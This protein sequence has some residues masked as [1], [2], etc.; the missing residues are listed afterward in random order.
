MSS[1]FDEISRLSQNKVLNY[2]EASQFSPIILI[3]YVITGSTDTTFFRLA[4]VRDI[5]CLKNNLLPF[6]WHNTNSADKIFCLKE[7]RRR[8]FTNLFKALIFCPSNDNTATG[9]RARIVGIC[10]FQVVISHC[11][12]KVNRANIW[13]CVIK[14]CYMRGFLTPNHRNLIWRTFFIFLNNL[15]GEHFSLLTRLFGW[16]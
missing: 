5:F 9:F 11:C 12:R 13:E 6:S 4:E 1:F 14:S 2:Y 16:N 7:I 8:Q 10:L 15:Q 3:Y